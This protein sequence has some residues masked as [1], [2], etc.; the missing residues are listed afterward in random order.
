MKVTFTLA[1]VLLFL[2]CHSASQSRMAAFVSPIETQQANTN[3]G[4]RGSHRLVY[5][6]QLRRVVLVDGYSTSELTKDQSAFTELWSWDGQQWALVPGSGSGPIV[7]YQS[8]AVYDSRRKRIISFGGRVGQSEI[9]KGDT[10]EWD[11]KSWRQMTDTSVG[12]RDHHVMAY[13]EAR[14]KTVLYGG[15][16]PTNPKLP[17]QEQRTWDW[18][19]DTWEWDGVKWTKIV[20]SGPGSRNVS[21]LTYDS[22]RKKVVLFGGYGEDRINR[23][24]TWTWDG[25]TWQKVSDEGPPGRGSSSMTFDRRAGVVLLYGGGVR[26]QQLEDMW[27]WDGQRWTEIKLT[28]P[29]PGKR[30]GHAMAY[31][32]ARNRTILYGGYVANKT[33]SDTWEWDGQSWSQVK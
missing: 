3:P 11:G 19:S 9:T 15:T 6:E 23:T 20:A 28:G 14:G 33:M 26:A 5:D 17:P 7:R 27:Q 31:D 22:Q 29:T 8:A 32:A 16:I 2:L 10:W 24:D 18:P 25:Q 13:D 1:T 4:P 21:T 12:I 30:V